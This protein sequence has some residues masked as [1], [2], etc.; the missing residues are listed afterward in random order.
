MA[1][2]VNVISPDAMGFSEASRYG[3]NGHIRGTRPG[4]LL[5]KTMERSTIY[6]ILMG[7]STINR[8]PW[9]Q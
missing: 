9:L 2:A 1:I 3:G 7:N 5:R 4:K 8:W 6:M